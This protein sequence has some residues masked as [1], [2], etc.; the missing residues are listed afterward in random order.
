MIKKLIYTLIRIELGLKLEEK[1]RFS[2]QKS[3]SDFYFIGKNSIY[4]VSNHRVIPSKV[5][6][7]FLLSDECEVIKL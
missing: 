1:F 3:E 7:T 2:N 6:L 4:K 5:P